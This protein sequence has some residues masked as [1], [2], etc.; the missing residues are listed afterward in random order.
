ME[1]KRPAN[2]YKS[3]MTGRLD[4]PIALTPKLGLI[5][6]RIGGA[7]LFTVQRRCRP[8]GKKSLLRARPRARKRPGVRISSLQSCP[9]L[10]SQT[11]FRRRRLSLLNFPP[12]DPPNQVFA[13]YALLTI[14]NSILQWVEDSTTFSPGLQAPS[15]KAAGPVIVNRRAHRGE[16]LAPIAEVRTQLMSVGWKH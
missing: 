7:E 9:R 14:P 1:I 15:A 16:C 8:G 11:K 13:K 12:G 10:H 5:A 4:F 3:A 2:A 6:S